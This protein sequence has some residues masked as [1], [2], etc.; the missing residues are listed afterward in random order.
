MRGRGREAGP[1][2]PV[3]SP[4]SVS[5]C[6]VAIRPFHTLQWGRR[7]KLACRC[8][9]AAALVAVALPVSPGPHPVS[10]V[11][12]GPPAA[13]PWAMLTRLGNRKWQVKSGDRWSFPRPSFRGRAPRGKIRGGRSRSSPLCVP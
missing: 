4:A 8:T 5:V 12:G 6:D 2:G 3:Y 13:V 9:L 11:G 1:A 10:L 7:A